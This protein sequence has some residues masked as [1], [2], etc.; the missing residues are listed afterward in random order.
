MKGLCRPTRVL[1]WF[2]GP[3]PPSSAFTQKNA[4]MPGLKRQDQVPFMFEDSVTGDKKYRM[5]GPSVQ[6]TQPGY[7]HW[8]GNPEKGVPGMPSVNQFANP[9]IP[10]EEAAR[11]MPDILIDGLADE[12]MGPLRT[13]AK[14]IVPHQFHQY[15]DESMVPEQGPWFS[16][17]RGGPRAREWTWRRNYAMYLHRHPMADEMARKFRAGD[18][19]ARQLQQD[20]DDAEYEREIIDHLLRGDVD[21]ACTLYKRMVDPPKNWHVY[22]MLIQCFAARGLL[23]DAV[24]VYDEMDVFGIPPSGEL[25]AALCECA[26]A[27]EKPVRVVWVVG[28]ARKR[29]PQPI[30]ADDRRRILMRALRYLCRDRRGK[31]AAAVWAALWSDGLADVDVLCAQAAVLSAKAQALGLLPLEAPQGALSPHHHLYAGSIATSVPVDPPAADADAAVPTAEE[32]AERVAGAAAAVRRKVGSDVDLDPCP[33]LRDGWEVDE[34]AA[35]LQLID[36]EQIASGIAPVHSARDFE[37]P[38]FKKSRQELAI[39]R[40][41]VQEFDYDEG[42]AQLQRGQKML[43]PSSFPSARQHSLGRACQRFAFRWDGPNTRFVATKGNTENR[44]DAADAVGTVSPEM[45]FDD[46]AQSGSVSSR[47]AQI[48]EAEF[49]EMTPVH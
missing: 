44:P 42:S 20:P 31:E 32:I 41:V 10:R 15:Y 8:Q 18:E 24:A 13:M 28:E 25:L 16:R 36:G 11:F 21:E 23:S 49:D 9:L 35:A 26:V 19:R 45:W 27:A 17:G 38:Y 12:I 7:A 4:R 29:W 5:Y 1:L 48:R 30:S 39:Q 43:R 2:D 22:T 33:M 6:R 46:V 47:A 3:P 37:M 34:V 40:Q 14:H